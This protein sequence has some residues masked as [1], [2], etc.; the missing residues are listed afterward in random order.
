MKA[1][2]RFFTFM[3]V[4]VF[5]TT[6]IACSDDDEQV[7]HDWSDAEFLV[8]NEK[9]TFSAT[10]G[11]A[12]LYI[13]STTTPSVTCDGSW[14]TLEQRPTDSKKMYVYNVTVPQFEEN[15]DRSATITVAA[16]GVTKTVEITQVARDGLIIE[17]TSFDVGTSESTIT[18]NLKAN[19]AFTVT[20]NVEWIQETGT[21]A[22]MA[23]YSRKFTIAAN[24][25]TA[26]TGSISFTL[27][28]ITESVTINQEGA[29]MGGIKANAVEI[30]K[31]MYPGWNLG[32]TLEASGSGVGAETAWQSTKTTQAVIDFVK[33]QGF[34]S[35]R[36][37]CSW[38]IH[39]T[40]GD[41]DAAW[42]ARVKE[43][44]NYCIA[45]GLYVV[46]ND[47]WDGGWIEVEGFSKSSD[48]YEPVDEATITAKSEMLK[49]IWTQIADE[50]KDY[51]E[52]L[53]F[54]G[55]NEPFQEYTKFNTRHKELTPILNRYNQAFVDAVRAT[56]GNNATRTLVVQGPATSTSSAVDP[57]I[58]FVMPTDT[59]SGYLMAEVHYYEPWDFCGQEDNGTWFW[60]SANHVSGS[61]HN[62]TWGEES[63][64]ESQF[65][66][67][68]STFV[69]K[70]YPVIIGEYGA[71]WRSLSVNQSEH[72][73]SV[74]S[75]FYEVNRQAVNN[76]LVTFAWDIN[77]PNQ[78]GEKG[79]MTI[80][81]RTN[82]SVFCTPA[83]E[84]I[85]EGTK[86]GSWPQ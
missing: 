62:P 42:M 63:W 73:A 43:V 74:K 34:R 4:A 68:K 76:G 59:E 81:N 35:V 65:R 51:D 53:L 39:S 7:T 13:Q 83:M 47:H 12:E 15:N 24:V 75:F 37:P 64:L 5:A 28:D 27:N 66:S 40:D 10:G 77:I 11:T 67:L 80:L 30:S 32:N 57:N 85:T 79:T 3:V 54:A 19:G 56:G 8:S 41:I 58:G 49:K 52:H 25:G 33:S 20:P 22:D 1:I 78:N 23:D 26:R 69:D 16:G 86:A 60:G 44:V 31:L 18:V 29:D 71:Q 82:L 17:N 45:D 72:D 48:S 2:I 84:G 55:L 38:Y 50:F 46:L 9:M 21:R 6:F 70:G 61:P 36:I 14:L